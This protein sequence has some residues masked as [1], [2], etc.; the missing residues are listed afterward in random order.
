M[1]EPIG[2]GLGDREPAAGHH[3]DE[4]ADDE[5]DRQPAGGRDQVVA[6]LGG[7]WGQVRGHRCSRRGGLVHVDRVEAHVG[8]DPLGLG[9]ALAG[10]AV[11]LDDLVDLGVHGHELLAGDDDHRVVH[12]GGVDPRGG[13]AEPQVEPAAELLGEVPQPVALEPAERRLGVVV[14][15][16]VAGVE[17]GDVG[18]GRPQPLLARPLA[19]VGDQA[20]ALELAQVVARGAGVGVELGGQGGRG[21]RPA[22]PQ[23]A[24][25]AG[26]QGVGEHL[27][28]ACRAARGSVVRSYVHNTCAHFLCTRCVHENCGSV[29][30]Q[31]RSGVRGWGRFGCRPSTRKLVTVVPCAS[32]RG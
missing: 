23:R 16:E 14:A 32:D 15:D 11:A 27:E 6:T 21:G 3:Q 29:S 2:G 19:G 8:G 9:V 18:G 13:P 26:A 22:H 1:T 20:D 12:A 24:H 17:V 4:D 31:V 7:A 5:A 28:L 25:Q 10:P 30:A